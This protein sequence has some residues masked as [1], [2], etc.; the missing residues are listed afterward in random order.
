VQA[1]LSSGGSM[2][3]GVASGGVYK[4]SDGG[5]TW[6]PPAPGNGM[7]RSETVWGLTEFLPGIVFAATQSGVYRSTDAGSTW[8]LLSDGITG[9]VLRVFKDEKAPN[10]Y[11]AAGHGGVFR[12]INAGTTWSKINNGSGDNVPDGIV[13]AM[14]QLSGIDLT[15]LYVG[16]PDGVFAGTTDHSLFPGEVKWRRI[17][18][19]NEGLGNNTIV[20]ALSN[21]LT[22]PG[23]MLAGTQ[24]NGGYMLTFTPAINTAIP[25]IANTPP[26]I[27]KVLTA[28]EGTW[29]GTETI[30]YEYQWQRCTGT[31]PQ[32]CS[33]V[34]DA[35]EKTFVVPPASVGAR[36]RVQVTG[37]NDFPTFGLNEADSAITAATAIAPGPLP[38]ANATL[39]AGVNIDDPGSDGQPQPGD[40]ARATGWSFNPI[41]TESTTFQWSVCKAAVC[42]EVPGAVGLTYTI[43][44]ADVDGRLCVAVT[45]RNVHGATTLECGGQTNLIVSEDPKQ[46]TLATLQ[47]S[48]YVG[49]T[50]VSTTGA[51][52]SAST[53]FVRRWMRCG[54]DGGSCEYIA[55]AS[56]ATY[57]L[58]NADLGKRL[59]TEIKADTNGANLPLAVFVYTPLSAVVTPPP[60]PP[61]DPQ[62]TPTPQ[63]GEPTPQPTP[64]P[65]PQPTPSPTPDTVAPVLGVSAVSSK[66]K[67]NTALKLK[68]TLSEGAS[69][70][71]SYE[72]KVSG[73]KVGKTCKAGA[74][75]GKKCTTYKKLA[76]VKV[77]GVGG[78]STVT[79]PKRKLAAGDYRVV[80]TPVDAAGNKG[81]AKTVTFKVLKK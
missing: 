46:L 54:A 22:T 21:F 59:K 33:D 71:V 72:R 4:S 45:G 68:A 41:A 69:L 29:T 2:L 77:A 75:K 15:R 5:A 12:T 42:T 78:S 66:L 73:R 35:T 10:I 38:G 48:A 53:H 26:T 37:K 70:S 1:L 9:T 27:G 40:V 58:T 44:E 20:W 7:V 31:L 34:E 6:K 60:P 49:D 80:V 18:K 36:W 28:N 8:T 14:K 3:A 76:T 56:S 64:N 51:W 67:P 25:T 63:G 43:R 30:E 81:A 57:T 19:N 23:T 11:Y 39:K 62:P 13:R 32:T 65:T 47:G 61:A 50:L 16:T 55:G 52:K 79:L 17:T 24:S 74:K